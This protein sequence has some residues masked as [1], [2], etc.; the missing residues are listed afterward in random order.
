MA[1]IEFISGKKRPDGT[2][3]TYKSLGSLKRLINYIQREDKTNEALM[4][5]IYCNP[6]TVYDEFVLTKEIYGKCPKTEG[7]ISRNRQAIHFVQGFEGWEVTPEQAREI[8]Y[9]FLKHEHFK[10]FQVTFAVHTDTSNIHTH[11]V[12][13]PVNYETGEGWH[14]DR[15]IIPELQKW[16]DELC[17]EHGLGITQKKKDHVKSGEYRAA[18]KGQ[19]WK[20]E[21]LHAGLEC[22]KVAKSREEFIEL[23]GKFGYKIRWVD[24]RK[25]ITYTTPQG[26][27]VNSDK[28]GYPKRG[29]TPLTKESLE[30]QF[31]LNRQVHKNKYKNMDKVQADLKYNLLRFAEKVAQNQEYNNYPFQQQWHNYGKLEGEALKERIN[32]LSK[33]QG[34]DWEQE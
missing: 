16:N 14:K 11:F 8:A 31:A 21:T 17:R 25:D 27:K 23:M 1:I 32:E 15:N 13:N 10:G 3:I 22:S 26:K 7:E 20:A 33:G 6:E 24:S 5:G 34:F 28:L 18:Q 9:E 4:G 29:Y 12:L 2:K 30:K 19:S